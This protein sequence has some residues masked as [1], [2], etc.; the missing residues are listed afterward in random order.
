MTG[1]SPAHGAFTSRAHVLTVRR[2]TPQDGDFV[3]RKIKFNPYTPLACPTAHRLVHL[4]LSIIESCAH[5]SWC[6]LKP[7]CCN[8]RLAGRSRLGN[9]LSY[10]CLVLHT[11]RCKEVAICIYILL[12]IYDL[13]VHVYIH[14]TIYL[15]VYTRIYTSYYVCMYVYRVECMSMRPLCT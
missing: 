4:Q 1:A 13:H 8:M 7:I 5:A 11:R 12:C 2:A 3:D 14:P 9:C 6:I 10:N 15:R